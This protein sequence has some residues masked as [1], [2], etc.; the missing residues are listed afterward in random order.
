MNLFG[1]SKKEQKLEENLEEILNTIEN[2][3]FT[4]I[5]SLC[6]YISDTEEKLEE[7]HAEIANLRCELDKSIQ[8][9]KL[10]HEKLNN[11]IKSNN[12]F[13]KYANFAMYSYLITMIQ[14]DNVVYELERRNADIVLSLERKGTPPEKVERAANKNAKK[15]LKSINK[16]PDNW[17]SVLDEK[18]KEAYQQWI[19][20]ITTTSSLVPVANAFNFLELRENRWEYF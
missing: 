2:S 13:F 5:N 14:R 12:Y 9:E 18:D 19:T 8:R 15:I 20:T 6:Q 17:D 4:D 7:N 3:G 10:T 11:C 16:R 1:K